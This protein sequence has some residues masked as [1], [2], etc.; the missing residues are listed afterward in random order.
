[1]QLVDA[2]ELLITPDDPDKSLKPV[3]FTWTVTGFTTEF[4]WI[5][6][7]FVN[8]R[9]ISD[10]HR[11]DTLSVTFWGIEYFKSYQNKEVLFGTTLYWPLY[12]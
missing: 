7:D 4:I 5:K 3:Q 8:P 9:D 2:L 10:D 11:F 1:M 12:G 6:L